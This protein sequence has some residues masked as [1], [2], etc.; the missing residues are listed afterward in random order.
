MEHAGSRRGKRA[1][2]TQRVAVV[3]IAGHRYDAGI[4]QVTRTVGARC[5]A[6]KRK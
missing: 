1:D 6:V 5:L 2:P 3:Q 4:A